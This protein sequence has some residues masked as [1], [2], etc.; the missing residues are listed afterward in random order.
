MSSFGRHSS[1]ALFAAT[2]PFSVGCCFWRQQNPVSEQVLLSRQYAQQGVNELARHNLGEAE[3]FCAQAVQ[4]APG[5]AAVRMH[6]AD[7]LWAQNRRNLALEQIE[8][9]VKKQPNDSEV[10]LRAAEMHL[11]AGRT[12]TALSEAQ[13]V[14]DLNPRSAEAWCLR[15]RVHRQ[16]GDSKRALADWQR[17]LV[18]DPRQREALR[19]SADLYR[20]FDDP[21]RALT[22]YQALSDTYQPGEEQPDVCVAQALTLA[23]LGRHSDAAEQLR[24]ACRRDPGRPE[25]L[26]LLAESESASGR[27]GAAFQAAEQ[28]VALAPDDSRYRS[29]LLRMAAAQNA[30]GGTMRR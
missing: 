29:A 14:I 13:R 26:L 7:V 18:Y 6:Y 27:D 23:S 3:R 1:L 24:I 12:E 22:N 20:E 19:L 15:G 21:Y 25:V 16:A 11:E 4:A 30:G 2:L 17:A 5:D 8:T 10:L 28:A 9:A